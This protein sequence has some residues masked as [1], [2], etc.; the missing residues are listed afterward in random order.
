MSTQYKQSMD[1]Y[2]G[3]DQNLDLQPC[4]ILLHRHS[5]EVFVYMSLH[6]WHTQHIMYVDEGSDQNLDF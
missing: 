3:S 6:Y 1:V 5:K 4:L 2:E